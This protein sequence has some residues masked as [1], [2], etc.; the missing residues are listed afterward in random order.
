ME[1]EYSVKAYLAY[2]WKNWNLQITD[3]AYECVPMQFFVQ[4]DYQELT[5]SEIHAS[6]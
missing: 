1:S 6:T 4:N 3:H 5:G 2:F